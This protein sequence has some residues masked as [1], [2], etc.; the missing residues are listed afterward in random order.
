[1]SRSE[2]EKYVAYGFGSGMLATGIAIK[3]A[4]GDYNS[5]ISV[6]MIIGL[7]IFCYSLALLLIK[8]KKRR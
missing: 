4:S 8:S 3:I 1:M 6:V 2:V 5:N 7:A